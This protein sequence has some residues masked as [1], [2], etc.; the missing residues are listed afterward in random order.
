MLEYIHITGLEDSP[1]G[2]P[3][4]EPYHGLE[5]DAMEAADAEKRDSFGRISRMGWSQSGVKRLSRLN[6][7]YVAWCTRQVDIHSPVVSRMSAYEPCNL[8][9]GPAIRYQDFEGEPAP[10]FS[11]VCVRQAARRAGLIGQRLRREAS[12]SVRPVAVPG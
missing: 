7:A 11:M 1:D 6:I 3:I 5:A 4:T 12:V 8:Q 9:G 2:A 10:I